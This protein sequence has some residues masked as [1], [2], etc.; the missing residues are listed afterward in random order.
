MELGLPVALSVDLDVVENHVGRIVFGSD[1]CRQGKMSSEPRDSGSF[2]P[3]DD[4]GEV[5]VE[6]VGGKAHQNHQGPVDVEHHSL[7][8]SQAVLADDHVH[9]VQVLDESGF[10]HRHGRS[11]FSQKVELRFGFGSR[12]DM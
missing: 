5:G 10:A 12:N 11:D 4:I 2:H 7:D 1:G 9:G 3:M 8:D 6:N